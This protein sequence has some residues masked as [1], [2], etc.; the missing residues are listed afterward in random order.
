MLRHLRDSLTVRGPD[1]FPFAHNPCGASSV[2]LRNQVGIL[3][4]SAKRESRTYPALSTTAAF[5]HCSASDT[6]GKPTS[7]S[8]PHE[9]GSG[10]A[11][12]QLLL[13]QL[14]GIVAQNP[15]AD[16]AL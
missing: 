11:E 7:L 13:K 15:P 1:N 6:G 9:P 12:A 2:A 3:V 10:S 14:A 8:Q 16:H 4:F 5:H